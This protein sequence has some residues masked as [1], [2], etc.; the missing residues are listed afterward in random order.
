MVGHSALD[1][2]ILVRIQV[3]QQKLPLSAKIPALQGGY[4]C[5]II[6][7]LSTKMFV[8][9]VKKAK[10]SMF[11]IFRLEPRGA[12]AEVG[13]NGTGFF[14]NS[15][16]YFISVAHVFDGASKSTKFLFLGRLPEQLQNPPLEIKEIARDDDLDIL[17]G[18]IETKNSVY[19]YLSNKI[20][21]EG[22][23]VCVSGYPLAQIS[24][25]PQGGLEVGGVRRYFQPSFVLDRAILKSQNEKGKIRNH[26]G[27]L[28][29]DVGLFGMSGGPV[30]DV[31]GRVV[32]MQG[33]VTQPRESKN[34]S[35][36]TITV[37]NAVVISSKQI[38]KFLKGQKI[39][40]NLLGGF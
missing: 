16:G 32:G 25:N 35:G 1:A 20:P 37:E 8:K 15:R 31:N 11:P 23:S 4:F 19:F 27:F 29:R 13:V 26:D 7:Y 3:P 6:S 18:R 12:Q 17:L 34:S 38:L 5:G 30:F 2:G 9:G 10:Q 21:E 22:R 28:V 39:R 24:Q 33:S 14:I 36:R 40:T